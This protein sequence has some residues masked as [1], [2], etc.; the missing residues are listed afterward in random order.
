MFQVVAVCHEAAL[1]ALQENLNATV[2]NE[3]HFL[4]AMKVI[5]PRTPSSL[6]EL[7]QNYLQT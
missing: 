4:S 5:T 7:Y 2:V 6:L 1:G 3:T